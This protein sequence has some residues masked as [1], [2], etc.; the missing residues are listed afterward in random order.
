MQQASILAPVFALAALTFVILT[1]IPIVRFRAAFEGKVGPED[2]KLGESVRV[3]PDVARPNRNYMN[4]LELPMLFYVVCLTCFVTNSVDRA[5]LTLAW[6]Y[7][8][9]RV[10]HSAVHITYNNVFHRLTAF[11][12]SVVVVLCMWTYLFIRLYL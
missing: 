1:L 11:G 4:L 5:I 7:V 3:P 6:I 8:A 10:F 12:A 2:F 9:L